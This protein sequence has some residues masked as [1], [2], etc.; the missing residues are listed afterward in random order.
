MTMSGV[1]AGQEKIRKRRQGKSKP[2][3][4]DQ[5]EQRRL[6]SNCYL[7]GTLRTCAVAENCGFPMHT[8]FART[9]ECLQEVS[10]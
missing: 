3:I 5:Q 9:C 1:K 7:R 4:G 6:Q 8:F 2:R 10:L